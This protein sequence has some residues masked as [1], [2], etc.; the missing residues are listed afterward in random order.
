MGR[1][2]RQF[3]KGG[4][5]IDQEIDALAGQH[6]AARG[7]PLARHLAAAAG[8]LVELFAELGDQRRA[9][10]SALRAK[11]VDLVSIVE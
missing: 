10:T 7:M 3:E 9:S 8:D 11:S 4:A 1:Q 6:L 5:G 2:R